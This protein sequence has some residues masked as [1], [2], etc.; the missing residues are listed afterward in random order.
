MI[1]LFLS[2]N[3]K[4]E[5]HK[6]LTKWNTYYQGL[7]DANKRSFVIRT[8]IFQDTTYFDSK[9]GYEFTIEMKHLICSAFVQ[10]TFG[11]RQD[12]LDVFNTI[13]V[14]PTPYSYKENSA[15]FNGDVNPFTNR[16]NLVWPVIEKGFV[17]DDDGMNLAI[18]EFGHCLLIENFRQSYLARTF[19]EGD[20]RAWKKLATEKI[21]LIGEGKYKI[22][23]RYGGRNLM[24]LFSV[25]L[26]VFFEQPNE[27]FSYSP[28][29]YRLT[30]IL[31]KQDPRN[32][33]N[34]KNLRI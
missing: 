13:F 14:T 21:P 29:F 4:N 27:F 2:R 11:L 19:N 25:T 12:V 7:S 22:F 30:C 18:H 17:V 16:I 15:L 6:N 20:L 33:T 1:S 32:R 31:L 23:R 34:P 26:E 24:E 10:I 9:P 5:C 3:R 28:K 8:L